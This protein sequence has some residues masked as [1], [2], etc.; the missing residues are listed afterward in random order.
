MSFFNSI[1]PAAPTALSTA[2]AEAL[3]SRRPSYEVAETD[4]GYTL[5]INLPGVSKEGLEITD[6]GGELRVL[7][8][9]SNKLPGGVVVLH[10]ESSEAPFELVLE[11]DNTVDPSKTEAELKDGVLSLK[12]SKAESAKPRKI[13][14]T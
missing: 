8:K 5:V 14:V 3:P 10:R 6:E 12:L 2:E 1:T 4:G 11:H 9:R 13:A 7:G